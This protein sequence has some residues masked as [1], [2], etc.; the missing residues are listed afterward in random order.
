MLRY[1][2]DPMH[3]AKS[4]FNPADN[5]LLSSSEDEQSSTVGMKPEGSGAS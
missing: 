5:V 3:E 2:R 4:M 1:I